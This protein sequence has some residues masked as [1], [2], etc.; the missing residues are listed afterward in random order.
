MS[1]PANRAPVS[2]SRTMLLA[3]AVLVAA[4]AS[5]GCA[6]PLAHLIGRAPNRYSPFVRGPIRLPPIESIAGVDQQFFVEV[7]PPEAT[8]SVSVIEPAPDRQPPRGTILVLHGYMIRSVWML[9]TAN[10]LADAGYRTVLVDLRG[11]GHSTGDWI[12]YGVRE[13]SDL[14]QVIDVL[15]QRGMIAGQ[16]GVYGISYGATTAIHLAGRDPRIGAV[17]AVA[18]FD[19]MRKE[20]PDYIRTALPGLGSMIPD[21]TY[22][23][24][25]DEAGRRGRFDPDAADSTAAIQQTSAPVLIVHGTNDWL[26]PT[27]NGIRL[28]EAAC[29]HSRLVLIPEIG[30]LMIFFDPT[31]DVTWHTRAWF[32]RFLAGRP[33]CDGTAPHLAAGK[34]SSGG[35]QTGSCGNK[36][37]PA[38]RASAVEA[39]TRPSQSAPPHSRCPRTSRVKSATL[40][41]R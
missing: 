6:V 25:I 37:R 17:V 14:S 10:M 3:I 23:R 7:G 28:H 27:G 40:S 12:T 9:G 31:G 13:A 33:W 34:S 38:S 1:Q 41:R 19:T 35:R 20:V 18:P 11:Q 16:L 4:I 24:A 21:A 32:D 2:A 30:H 26:V 22:Q 29:T 5:T 39:S 36:T 15:E 8:L